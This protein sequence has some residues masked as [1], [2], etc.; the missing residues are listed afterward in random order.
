MTNNQGTDSPDQIGQIST[1]VGTG[2]CLVVRLQSGPVCSLSK[3]GLIDAWRFDLGLI[4][5]LSWDGPMGIGPVSVRF[6]HIETYIRTGQWV[7]IRTRSSQFQFRSC[8]FSVST[9]V[10]TER[11]LTVRFRSGNGLDL[12]W[13]EPIVDGPLSVRS[14]SGLVQLRSDPVSFWS[15]PYLSY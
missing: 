5:D 13:D 14:L 8:A 10:R 1:K 6:G 7:L 15:G 2:W 12:S 11:W 3:L 4:L 9:K